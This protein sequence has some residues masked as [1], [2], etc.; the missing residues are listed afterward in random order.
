MLGYYNNQNILQL[1]HKVTFS[2]EIDKINQVLIDDIIDKMS[3]LVQ[4]GKYGA[5]NTTYT[6]AMVYYVIKFLSEGYT[7]QEETTCDGKI[8]T[9]GE[10]VFKAQYM[11][12]MQDNKKWYWE[13]LPQKTILL[14]QQAQL[15][16]HVWMSLSSPK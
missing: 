1:L 2:E 15:Y 9:A 14:L 7:L 12:C 16:I 13:I 3:A 10:L 6:T 8:I 5:I 4:T 11:N